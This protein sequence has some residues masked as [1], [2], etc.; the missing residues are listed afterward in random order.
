MRAQDLTSSNDPAPGSSPTVVIAERELTVGDATVKVSIDVRR[1]DS[2]S[3]EWSVGY[4]IVGDMRSHR[5]EF[6]GVHCMDELQYLFMGLPDDLETFRTG[7]Q[8]SG[9]PPGTSGFEQW[10]RDPDMNTLFFALQAQYTYDCCLLSDIVHPVTGYD[11]MQI[12]LQEREANKVLQLR[13]KIQARIVVLAQEEC[14]DS[15]LFTDIALPNIVRFDQSSQETPLAKTDRVRLDTGKPVSIEIWKPRQAD[16]TSNSRWF[17][18]YRILGLDAPIYAGTSGVDSM[19]S[20]KTVFEAIGWELK[21]SGVDVGYPYEEGEDEGWS[22]D[23]RFNG[24][25]RFGTFRTDTFMRHVA[26]CEAS[27]NTLLYEELRGGRKTRIEAI[28]KKLLYHLQEV[29]R[30]HLSERRSICE[31]VVPVRSLRVPEAPS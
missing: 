9:G 27:R 23:P 31:R 19:E 7:L 11:G 2:A 6:L 3:E 18:E 30:L 14:S 5:E 10:H 17:C 12:E 8:F 22:I 24:F 21:N 4:D 25:E 13:Q 15:L 28:E 1:P 26:A 16:E 29:E 20:L